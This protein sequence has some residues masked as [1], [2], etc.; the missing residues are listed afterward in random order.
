MKILGVDIGG[1]KIDLVLYDNSS[2]GYEYLGK[3]PTSERLADLG[4]YVDEVAIEHEV[5]AIG[6]S[7]AAWIK[8]GRPFFSPNLPE[9][10]QFSSS[11]PVF[12]ENDANCFGLFAYDRLRLPHIFAV[13]LGTGIGSGIIT[14]GR[15]YTGN[16]KA[17]EVGHTVIDQERQC[18]C[19]GVGHLEAYFSG[20]ALKKKYGKDVKELKQDEDHFYSLPEFRIFCRQIANVVTVLDPSAV[21]FGGGIGVHLNRDK[22]EK[23]IYSF[24]MQP[25][26]PQIEILEDPLAVVKG[27]CIM[28]W[29]RLKEQE[30]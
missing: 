26:T 23:G 17:G 11:L 24:L 10:P 12:F 4:R 19:G 27:A 21:V 6:V 30:I 5:D 29:R 18:T 13:T 16:G 14:D 3:Y 28:G 7:I 2:N 8:E 15:L 25:F 1:T 20:W 9:T 22:L